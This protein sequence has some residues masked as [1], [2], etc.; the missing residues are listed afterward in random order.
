MNSKKV[1]LRFAPS[2]TGFLHIGGARTALYN[3]LF[4][5]ANNGSFILRIEDTDRSR[6]TEE[7]I[8][9]IISSLRWLGLNWDEEPYRQTDRLSYYQK[10]A[11][12]LLD[13]GKA[14]FCYCT[15]DELEAKRHA[16]VQA[17]QPPKYDGRCQELSL[18]ERKAFEREGR[19]PAIRFITPREGITTVSDLIRGKVRFENK[20]LSD[21]IILR[22]DGFPTYNFA[23]VI[24]D[25][26]MNITHVIRG[27]DHL[28]NTPKQIFLYQAL[29]LPIPPFVHLPLILGPDRAPLSKRHGAIS[30]E[31]YRT[32]GYISEAMINYLALLGWSYDEKST[33]FS[34]R[35]LIEKFSLDRVSK[36]PAIFDPV[37]L[38]WMN[39]YYIRHTPLGELTK[40]VIPVFQKAGFLVGEP[41]A[42]TSNWLEKVTASVQ[43]RIK[44]LI[45]VAELTDFFFKEELELDPKA[46]EEILSAPAVPKILELAENKLIS[47]DQ[48]EREQIETALRTILEELKLKPGEVF[49]PIRVATTGRTASPPLFE[50]LEILG[51][52]KTLLRLRKARELL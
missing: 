14:Y 32:N 51:K 43:E 7:A 3:W 37:K 4:A 47:L 40:K 10:A 19:K 13:E 9:A 39:A 35:E 30:I 12:R 38:E 8:D 36:S 25:A 29:N 49:Q 34:V 33:I 20:L 52:E 45:D 44:R 24:D 6:S 21:F 23:V 50:T 28:S 48:F 31:E 1:K 26:A 11:R 2:P 18:D 42:E 46:T 41:D 15:P 22:A 5:R 16:A 27:E 17:G